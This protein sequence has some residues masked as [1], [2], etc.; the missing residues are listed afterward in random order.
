MVSVGEQAP[1]KICNWQAHL[2]YMAGKGRIDMHYKVVLFGVKDTSETIIEFIHN[3]ICPIDLIVTIH[4][5]VLEKNDVS[6]YKGLTYFTEKYKIP[7][8][9]VKSYSLID[10]E[11]KAFFEE[12][13]F[14]IGISMGWQ[15]LIPGNVLNRFKYGVFGFHGSCGYL[16][17]GR[18]RSPLNWSV[19]LGDERFILNMF[20][21]DEKADSPNIFGNEMFEINPHDNIRVLQYKVMMCSKSLIKKLLEA[22]KNDNIVIK[23]ESK[24]FD[25][26]YGKRTPADGKIDFTKR[27]REIYNLI[28]G[29]TAPFPGAYLFVNDNKIKVWD[30]VPFDGI[31]DFSA[32][33]PGEVI[34]VYDGNPIVR[35]VDGSLLIRKYE[36][37]YTIKPGDML[38]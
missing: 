30:A 33:A 4:P 20:Q 2:D 13:T 12:N 25:S 15:R 21:Y 23:R 28:R 32:Y 6:G 24:D 34:D 36:G 3:T 31:M 26:W 5:C 14:D 7:V 37:E 27:T 1:A 9:Q 10:E 35:C 16:P 17:F 19:I 29:V 8:F 11:T 18:G 38:S 22:Y